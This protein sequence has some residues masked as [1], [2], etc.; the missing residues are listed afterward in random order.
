MHGPSALLTTA[1][2]GALLIG[3]PS[4]TYAAPKVQRVKNPKLYSASAL[5]RTRKQAA[6][7]YKAGNG[8]TFKD[9]YKFAAAT[10][11]DA[12]AT[13]SSSS[14]ETTFSAPHANVWAQLTNDEAASVIEWL[15]DSSKS[16]LNLTAAEN[17]TAWD[18]TISV[19]DALMPNKTA[20]LD[21][22]E[23]GGAKPERWAKVSLMN[24]AT[25]EPTMWVFCATLSCLQFIF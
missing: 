3:L 9:K 12:N 7:H 16:G 19:V 22:V 14:N 24:G 8:E 4:A 20:V 1:V 23:N 25:E 13:S 6:E 5:S 15:H 21:Y 2:L 17:A 18:N 10:S 11:S